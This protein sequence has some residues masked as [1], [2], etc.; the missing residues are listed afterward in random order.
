MGICCP[1]S[2]KNKNLE[3]NEQGIQSQLSLKDSKENNTIIPNQLSLTGINNNSLTNIIRSQNNSTVNNKN[4][5]PKDTKYE[6]ELNSKFKYFD[7]MWYDPNETNDSY[8][9]IKCFK[10]VRYCRI[11]DL[12]IIKELFKDESLL[13]WIVITPGSKGE[14]LIQNLKDFDCIK[15]FFI[16]CGNEKFHENWAKKYKKVVCITSSPEILCQKFIQFN[17]N[18]AFQIKGNLG[19]NVNIIQKEQLFDTY[20]KYMKLLFIDKKKEKTKYGQFCIKSLKYLN[21]DDFKEEFIEDEGE[22]SEENNSPLIVFSNFFKKLKYI[23]NEF[24]EFTIRSIKQLIVISIWFNRYPF[25][26]HTLSF[27]DVKELF[28]KMN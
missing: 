22:N 2:S 5:F 16:F 23:N 27:Q 15:A 20:Y 1:I 25:L 6:K 19:L 21:S 8:Q 11:C 4:N 3:K 18:Y 14:E 12:E 28:Q 9:F 17:K 24:F 7:V 10:N 13:K 26:F